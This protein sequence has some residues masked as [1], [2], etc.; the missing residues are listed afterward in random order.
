[1]RLA[2]LKATALGL[3]RDRAAFAL[4]FILPAAIFSIFSLVFSSAAGGDMKVSLAL[5]AGDDVVSESLADD[6]AKA[7]E[8]SVVIPATSPD[9][10]AALVRSGEADVGYRIEFPDGAS[11]PAFTIYADATRGGAAIVAEGALARLEPRPDDAPKPTTAR[12]TVNPVNAAAPMAAYF[13]AGVAMLFLFLSGFQSA[14]TLLEERDAGVM[15]RVA[16]GPAG[17][18]SAID[19]KFAFIVLQG[20]AQ[21]GVILATAALLFGV[22]LGHAPAALAI[23]AFAAAFCAAGVALAV[24]ALC[25]SRA[26]A[27]AI[28]TVFS[29]VAAAIGGSMA[30]RFLM[31]ES[32]RQFGAWT[33]NA[34]GIDAFAASLWTGGGLSAAAAPAAVLVA[35]GLCGL[36]IAHISARTTLRA[37]A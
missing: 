2:I 4:A 27:H 12:V 34:Q 25:R 21:I 20:L 1:M 14:L 24:T 32:V 31:P 10:L 17:V 16:A 23:A 13:A 19:G 29:L 6:L 9:E 35:T 28:G 15:E 18:A 11:A 26:Q 5:M 7:P 8:I 30:P 33:P 22:D 37:D 3:W 36:V